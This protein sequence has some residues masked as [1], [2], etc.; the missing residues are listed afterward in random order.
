MIRLVENKDINNITAIYN[1]YIKESFATFEVEEVS[2]HEM[3]NRIKAV[4][5]D[6][7]P[8]L[9]AE[10]EQGIVVGYAYANKWK[11]RYAYRFSAEIT[12]YIEPNTQNSG[13]GTRLYKVLFEALRKT[14]IHSVIAGITLPNEPSVALHEKF[15][16]KQVAHF[17][18]VGFKFE[19][20]LDTGYWQVSII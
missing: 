10:N 2:V 15:G 18:E 14:Q 4:R 16:M 17:K 19:Q 9:V 5:N 13:L 1:Y 12:V 11:A 20:W 6:G 8:W 3:K 7:Y